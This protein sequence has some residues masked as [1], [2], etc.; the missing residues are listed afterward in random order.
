MWSKELTGTIAPNSDACTSFKSFQA[1]LAGFQTTGITINAGGDAGT[2]YTCSDAT[3]AKQITDAFSACT[4]S[5]SYSRQSFSCDGHTWVIGRCISWGEI[6]VG[7]QY[8]TCYCNYGGVSIRP[9]IGSY[10]GSYWGY[11]PGGG[12]CSSIETQTM[13]ITVTTTATTGTT[14][15][16]IQNV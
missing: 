16:I 9:C 11:Y 14:Y 5:C 2:T 3:K 8:G 13:S 6:A 7:S 4:G 10:Y 12:F 1:S 15:F